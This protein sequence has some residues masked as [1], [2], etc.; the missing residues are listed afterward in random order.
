MKLFPNVLILGI[1]HKRYILRKSE[2]AQFFL[3]YLE[4][5]VLAFWRI[6]IL[7]W[8]IPW[9]KKVGADVV[10][11]GGSRK[12][13]V[14]L[15]PIALFRIYKLTSSSWKVNTENDSAQIVCLI[16]KLL[17]S[18]KGWLQAIVALNNWWFV[19]WLSSKHFNSWIRI[20]Y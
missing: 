11:V 20:H 16:R 3:L 4:N 15:G 13:L 1:L 12:T 18:S 10:W 9:P 19:S 8:N 7:S 17:T 2:N 14:N 6:I 5:I